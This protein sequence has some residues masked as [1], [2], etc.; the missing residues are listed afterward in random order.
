MSKSSH[1][2]LHVTVV[3]AKELVARKGNLYG[4][5]IVLDTRGEK[6]GR[7]RSTRAVRISPSAADPQWD[8]L[9]AFQVEAKAFSGL[10]VRL[11]D[12]HT[13]RRDGFLGQVTIKFNTELLDAGDEAP[14]DQWFALKQ[15]GKKED[16]SGSVH[17]RIHYGDHP[18][19]QGQGQGQGQGKGKQAR[20]GD[21]D[22]EEEDEDDEEAKQRPLALSS[23]YHKEDSRLKKSTFVQVDEDEEAEAEEGHDAY[24][25]AR[26]GKAELAKLHKD[27]KVT[28]SAKNLEAS[29]PSSY[30]A[31]PVKGL[32]GVNAGRWYYEV[33]M[34]SYGQMMVGWCTSAYAKD[35]Q[36]DAWTFDATSA[37]TMRKGSYHA[38]FGVRCS[39]NEVIGVGIDIKAKTISFWRNGTAL[40]EAWTDAALPE[41]DRFHPLIELGR[42]AHIKVNFGRDPFVH[43][44][45]K[46][47]YHALHCA[48]SDS[49]LGALAK[50][51]DQYKAAGIDLTNS[52][53]AG[54]AIQGNGTIKLGEDLGAVD[55][56]DPLMMVLAWKLD[57][58]EKWT[59]S[60]QEWMDGF[61]LYGC[62]T[63]G[64]IAERAQQ[65]KR[66][67][68]ADDEQ[69]QSFYNF[70]FPYL[71]GGE[72]NKKIL[73]FDIVELVWEVLVKP[74]GWGLYDEWLAF[75][76]EKGT[77]AV[78]KDAFQQLYEFMALYP[79]DLTDYDESAAW[80]LLFDEFVEWYRAKHPQDD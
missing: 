41:A 47:G 42:G 4:E 44:Q 53:D 56:D 18:K 45:T 70:M 80:P 63:L 28:L 3:G 61:A 52:A 37:Q 55:D 24:E 69:F 27:V 54:D 13:F 31:E 51:F 75:H 12:K 46:A 76:R 43:P 50:L 8:A 17:L 26:K 60:R 6:L 30:S 35:G 38:S 20:P 79:R 66:E 36:G 59:I 67:V 14:I 2:T 73:E 21:D 23:H 71:L 78:T 22:G 29:N 5:A 68:K 15:R 11:W 10:M 16:V 77:K 19:G 72:T 58:E 74:R 62:H 49:E 57:C 34:T 33:K 65:W 40:G 32:V 25:P 1:K 48:L 7:S 9:L 64:Q 39:Q